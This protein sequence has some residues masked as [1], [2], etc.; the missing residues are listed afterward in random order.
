MP[1]LVSVPSALTVISFALAAAADGS[2]TAWPTNFDL[3][4]LC[5]AEIGGQWLWLQ[6]DTGSADL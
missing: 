1:S 6:F 4:F 5:P 3:E 2:V